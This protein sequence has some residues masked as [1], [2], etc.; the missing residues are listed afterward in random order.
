MKVLKKLDGISKVADIGPRE[1]MLRITEFL[2]KKNKIAIIGASAKPEKW[3]YKIYKKLKSAGFHIYPI[4]PKYN[5]IDQNICYHALKA[6]PEKPDVV[7]TIVKPEITEKIVEQC[8]KLNIDKL[9]MQ[10]GSESEKSINFCKDNN[11]KVVHNI[12]FVINGLKES[13]GD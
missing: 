11:I 8:K 6:L 13:F 9:W 10:P 4:N 5:D 1:L 3:G 12:C 2:N 7:I